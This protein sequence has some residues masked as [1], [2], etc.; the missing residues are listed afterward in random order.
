MATYVFD[1]DGTICT[2]QKSGEYHLAK[3]IPEM[4]QK[5]NDLYDQG[6]KIVIHTARGMNTYHGFVELVEQALLEPTH[7]WLETNGVRYHELYMGKP[8]GDFYI[9][10]K[11]VNSVDFIRRDN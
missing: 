9:D 8:P 11:G 2:Q 10:D 3:P 6:H 7:D 5:V 4:I 1:L